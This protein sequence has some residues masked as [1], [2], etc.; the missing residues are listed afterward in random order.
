MVNKKKLEEAIRYEPIDDTGIFFKDVKVNFY[1]A[2]NEDMFKLYGTG[3]KEEKTYYRFS[4]KELASIAS[5]SDNVHWLATHS[6]GL[7]LHFKSNSRYIEIRT[8]E[9]DIPNMKN[10]EFFA[11][12]GFD[13]Y[14]KNKKDKQY[15]FHNVSFPNYIDTK[16]FI[17]TLGAFR[18]K[19]ERE[20]ILYFPLYL[21]VLSLEIGLEEGSYAKP[22]FIE[23]KNRIV[24]Y[25][26]SI[27]Q[28]GCVSR[29]GLATT[30]VLSRVLNK[31]VL[32]YGF[33][34]AGLLEREIGE[35]IATRDNIELLII[36]AEPNAGCDKWMA[37]NFELFLNEFYK[38]Y[39]SLKVIVMN[40]IQMNI[41]EY[42]PRN[43]RIKDYYEN[44]L[45][46]MVKKYKKKGKEIYFV[47]NYHLYDNKFLNWTEYTV[48]GVHPHELGM[49][50]LTLNYLKNIKKVL[51]IK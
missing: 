51:K 7:S 3:V 39:P 48:D 26:T 47:D 38:R 20:F 15:H 36:D 11:Q 12:C 50:Y 24:V 32:N 17:A 8:V 31:D 34:G 6:A 35:I 18:E 42:I 2:L 30:N 29:P 44:F 13:L 49:Y 10:M 46:G 1:D 41:D 27:I 37:N 23:D 22:T 14:Y 43:K 45:R 9:N 25:G 19:E 16:K 33:S 40:K 4:N 21:G 5:V 28:G